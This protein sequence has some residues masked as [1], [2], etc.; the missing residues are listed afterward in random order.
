MILISEPILDISTHTH[1]TSYCR[2]S[3]LSASSIYSTTSSSWSWHHDICNCIRLAHNHNIFNMNQG[4]S[5][6]ALL[7]GDGD[8]Y[9]NDPG[10]WVDFLHPELFGD[11]ENL[12]LDPALFEI[13]YSHDLQNLFLETESPPNIP[14][15]YSTSTPTG[16]QISEQMGGQMPPMPVS[17]SQHGYITPNVLQ[18]PNQMDAVTTPPSTLDHQQLTTPSPPT[19]TKKSRPCDI[20]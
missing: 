12:A 15:D 8:N 3:F 10:S 16:T 1:S 11:E 2:Q 4:H 18:L 20:R 6:D 17:N 9:S 7:V 13:D 14:I 19:E 5:W